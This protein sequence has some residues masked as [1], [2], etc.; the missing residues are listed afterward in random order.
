M[1][2]R[3]FITALAAA[4]PGVALASRLLKAKP[5]MPQSSE[6]VAAPTAKLTQSKLDELY[7]DLCDESNR[8]HME[9]VR[10]SDEVY[11]IATQKEA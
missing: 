5:A 8:L 6:A 9:R 10:M 7:R 11:N 2:R 1:N 4:I 3:S